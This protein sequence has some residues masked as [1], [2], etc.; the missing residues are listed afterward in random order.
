MDVLPTSEML[1]KF[2]LGVIGVIVNLACV[3]AIVTEHINR[4]VKKNM[5][6]MFNLVH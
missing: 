3:A 6:F 4:P 5:F 2:E 1:M